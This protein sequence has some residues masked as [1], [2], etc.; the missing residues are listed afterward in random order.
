M[1]NI[2]DYPLDTRQLL[3]QKRKIKRLLT[4][5]INE[6][7]AI[8]KKIA[9]LG[10]STT[11]EV[12][13]QIELFLLHNAIVPDFYQSEYGK[14]W[15]DAMFAGN[16][17]KSFGP[18]VIYIHT[19]WRNITSFPKITDN[20]EEIKNKLNFETNR[21]KTMWDTL[22]NTCHCPIIQNNF[23]RPDYRLLGNMDISNIHGRSNFIFK[24]N[25][26]LYSYA[27]AHD[28]VYVNDIDYLSSEFGITSWNDSKI[29]SLYKYAMPLEAI[30]ALAHSVSN[31][32]KAIYGKNK[33][34]LTLDLDNTLWGGVIGEDGI[35]GIE[36]GPE[37]PIGQSYYDFQK[38]CKALKDIGVIL[39]INSKN[40]KEN[41][42]LGFTHENS[43][44]KVS[45]FVSIK[46]NWNSKAQNFEEMAHELSLG[47][48]SFVFVDDNPA[49]REIVAQQ[50]KEVSIIDTDDIDT[51]LKIL[52]RS[53]F[54]EC[55]SV[56]KEDINKTDLYRAKVEADKLLTSASN[57]GEYLVSL[58]MTA[59][60][61]RFEEAY[62]HRIAQLTNKSNQFN[63]T[64]L[65]LTEDDVKKMGNDD[66]YICLCGRLID[67]F[68]DN[69]IVAISIG[70]I[71]SNTLYI[72]LWLMSCRVLKREME[73]A[74]MN[75]IV[76]LAKQRGITQ[77]IGF[78]YPSLKNKMVEKF[79]EQFGFNLISDD[80]G[81]TTWQIDI[82]N[83]SAK[84]LHMTVELQ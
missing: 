20:D 11:N 5:S 68:A 59:I 16:E 7:I 73:F 44:L 81:K 29:W 24:L 67:K 53:G 41:A 10:G 61:T 66:N 78:Y 71:K 15:E 27:Q 9:I 37:L 6:N 39:A 77:I 22:I 57:Y 8:H 12:K 40:D 65:R 75:S 84:K 69:G 3:T 55:I 13:D 51:F 17:L 48:D 28:T 56:S 18:D 62:I 30:P 46:A 70:E 4:Q 34:V 2:F 23:D 42:L 31:I 43:I 32:I 14:F 79:Y 52:D 82:E 19:N 76:S 21:F 26:M 47:L 80:D 49:E 50:A 33:K 1:K 54:F 58:K 45:D 36:I 60:I 35:E 63:L 25:E 74:M 83:Y 38:Y 72:R 64:T